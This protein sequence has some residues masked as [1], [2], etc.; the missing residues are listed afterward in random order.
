MGARFINGAKFAVSQSLAAAVAM[1]AVSN[2]DPAVALT[3]TP[4]ANGSVVVLTSGWPE[5]S[6]SVARSAGQVAATS[7]Q[8][9][10]VDTTDVV[11]YPPTEGV[12][13]FQ[14]AGSFIGINQVRDITSS[15]GDQQFF[16]YKYVEDQSSRE[17][18]SPTSKDAMS[19]TYV[20]DYDPS[21]PWYDA[22]IE[23][24]RLK[25]PVVLRETL[26]N[27]DVIYYY[28]YLSFNKVPTKTPDENMTVK[29]TFSHLA[30]PIR[31]AAP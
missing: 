19:D 18:Q 28:G 1:T 23:L 3:A 14:V 9:E 16:K 6:G 4:P 7:F 27:G 20:L 29:M 30:D 10:G 2:A 21:L 13:T 17:R 25:E 11:R 31:Y 5:L 22:L 26:P 12:G 24:D 15:G 8:I